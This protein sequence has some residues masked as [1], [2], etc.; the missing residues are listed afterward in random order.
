MSKYVIKSV[1][2]TWSRNTVQSALCCCYTALPLLQINWFCLT[3][4]RFTLRLCWRH[5]AVSVR[6]RIPTFRSIIPPSASVARNVPHV[7]RHTGR[8]RLYYTRVSQKKGMKNS[9]AVIL[10]R[11]RFLL[12]VHGWLF[13]GQSDI[14]SNLQ[15]TKI[16][17]GE[18]CHTANNTSVLSAPHRQLSACHCKPW[19]HITLREDV[20]PNVAVPDRPADSPHNCCIT[21]NQTNTPKLLVELPRRLKRTISQTTSFVDFKLPDPLSGVYTVA[22]TTCGIAIN[23]LRTCVP[24]DFP[25]CDSS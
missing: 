18:V 24:R 4:L 19:V 23:C 9:L 2:S 21:N 5:D 16:Q 14:G 22:A 25:T 11:P 6:N 15:Q 1:R 17:S 3:V 10:P 20:R 12:E 8:L 13:E 7:A